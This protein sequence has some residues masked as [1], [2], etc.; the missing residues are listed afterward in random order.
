MKLK[1]WVLNRCF[2]YHTDEPFGIGVFIGMDVCSDRCIFW[3]CTWQWMIWLIASIRFAD[4]PVAWIATLT[5]YKVPLHISFPKFR[6]A[7]I[8]IKILPKHRALFLTAKIVNLRRYVSLQFKWTCLCRSPLMNILC[9]YFCGWKGVYLST[10]PP[11]VAKKL[12]YA[13]PEKRLVHVFW[14]VKPFLGNEQEVCRFTKQQHI[15]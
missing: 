7:Q 15:C 12:T 10:V 9:K 13:E 6:P 14:I 3:S 8:T 2:W 5:A 11:G 1:M 4:L